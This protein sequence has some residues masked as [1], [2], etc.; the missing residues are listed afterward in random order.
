MFSSHGVGCKLG[1]SVSVSARSFPSPLFHPQTECEQHM[2]T[3]RI[4]TCT[5]THTTEV[6]YETSTCMSL[7]VLIFKLNRVATVPCFVS[8]LIC[9]VV[10]SLMA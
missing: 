10:T 5:R 4:V 6:K 3:I 8:P 1:A 9:M 7:G 2:G